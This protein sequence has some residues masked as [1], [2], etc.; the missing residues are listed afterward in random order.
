MSRTKSVRESR[1]SFVVDVVVVFRV[2]VIDRRRRIDKKPS[3]EQTEEPSTG[4][5]EELPNGTN[6]RTY[7]TLFLSVSII[8]I[9]VPNR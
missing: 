2:M 5:R 8:S 9:T 3:D 7:V 6:S 4:A 1:V